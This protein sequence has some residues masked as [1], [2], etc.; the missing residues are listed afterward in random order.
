MNAATTP[1]ATAL[2]QGLGRAGF[3]AG[4]ALRQTGNWV[5]KNPGLSMGIAGAGIAGAGIAG[6]SLG[7]NKQASAFE[8]GFEKQAGLV[9]KGIKALAEHG[10]HPTEALGLGTLAVPS[11]LNLAGKHQSEKAKDLYEVGGLGI[12]ALPTAAHYAQKLLKH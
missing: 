1:G 11:V 9:S 6:A 7:S 10:L 8:L 4:T 12:L 3:T 2:K 5:A